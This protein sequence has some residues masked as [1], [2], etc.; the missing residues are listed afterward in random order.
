MSE[1]LCVVCPTFRPSSSPRHPR[2][3]QVCDR[4]RER[5]HDD[6]K[7]IAPAY[8]ELD[9]AAV[10]GVSE[11]LTRVFESKPPLNLNDLSLLCPG[12]DTPLGVLD[13]WVRDWALD[14]DQTPPQCTVVEMSGW[15]LTRLEWACDQH[16]AIDEF[17]GNIRDVAGALHVYQ[18]AA[19]KRGYSAGRCPQHRGGWPCD[20]PLYLDPYDTVIECSRCH[21]KWHRRDGGWIHLR[22]QQDNARVEAAAA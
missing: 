2:T 10:R 6:L 13:F 22:T 7:A 11:I 21:T 19:E 9:P 14:L 18:R 1:A 3:P 17:A 12:E 15:L 20:T 16:P 4:C 8:A 5:L